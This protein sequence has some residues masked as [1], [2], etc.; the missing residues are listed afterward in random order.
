MR[1]ISEVG[2]AYGGIALGVEC[3]WPQLR[4]SPA[5]TRVARIPRQLDGQRSLMWQLLALL[6][7]RAT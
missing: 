6:L 7:A 3:A 5:P 1:S 4:Q 2:D